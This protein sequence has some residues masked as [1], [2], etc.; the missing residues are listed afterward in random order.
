MLD[1]QGDFIKSCKVIIILRRGTVVRAKALD[2]N[3][4]RGHQLIINDDQTTTV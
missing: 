2:M 4:P 3:D 1:L